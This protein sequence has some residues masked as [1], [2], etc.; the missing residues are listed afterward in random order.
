MVEAFIADG[1]ALV[2]VAG[3]DCERI[4]DI[5][6]ELVVGNGSD[7]SRFILTS[8]H[9]GESLLEVVEFARSSI[10]EPPGEPQV[11]EL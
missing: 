8:A 7:T 1:V 2:A 9:P 11:V 6:D 3:V 4:E 10:S 5:I